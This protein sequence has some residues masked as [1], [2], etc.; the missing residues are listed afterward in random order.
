MGGR[1]GD[2]RAEARR[3]RVHHWGP[4]V[5]HRTTAP[6][7]V[8]HRGVGATST[9]RQERADWRG[10][11]LVMPWVTLDAEWV[12]SAGQQMGS[13]VARASPRDILT[14]PQCPCCWNS[15]LLV[16]LADPNHW[17]KSLLDHAPPWRQKNVHLSNMLSRHNDTAHC[18]RPRSRRCCVVCRRVGLGRCSPPCIVW[19]STVRCV[20]LHAK[21]EVRAVRC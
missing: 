4:S 3:R 13:M 2:G 20:R 12:P 16:R 15:A 8:E 19:R 17:I 5:A 7:P 1:V 10:Q 14:S 9:A 11:G 18:R 6:G 21:G